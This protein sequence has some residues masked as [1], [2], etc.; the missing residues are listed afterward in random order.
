MPPAEEE[1]VRQHGGRVF[2]KPQPYAVLID[3]LNELLKTPTA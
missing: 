2:Y 1:M 3:E